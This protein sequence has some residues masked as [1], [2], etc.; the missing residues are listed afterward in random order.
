MS[1]N[2]E[3]GDIGLPSIQMVCKFSESEIVCKEYNSLPAV[4]LI[5]DAVKLERH[6][7]RWEVM[8]INYLVVHVRTKKLYVTEIFKENILYWFRG[9]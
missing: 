4:E 5:I 8:W 9:S 7:I 2:A 1:K 3:D 6:K